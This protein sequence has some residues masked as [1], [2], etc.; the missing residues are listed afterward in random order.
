[1]FNRFLTSIGAASI[2]LLASCSTQQL[3]RQNEQND[4]VYYSKARAVEAEEQVK[5]EAK[6]ADYVT[7]QELYG[8]RNS[9]YDNSSDYEEGFYDG[10]YS[11]RLYRFNNYTPWRSYYDSYYDYRF[12]PFYG[13]NYYSNNYYNSFYNGAS[14]GIYIGV[15]RPYGYNYYN[16]WNFYGSQYY[17][18]YWGP[19]SY[20]NVYNPYYGG[21]YSY[22]GGNYGYNGRPVVTNPNY[23]TRPNRETENIRSGV[24][25]PD[26]RISTNPSRPQRTSTS[27]KEQGTFTERTSDNSQPVRVSRPSRSE[28]GRSGNVTQEKNNNRPA[29]TEVSRPSRPSRESNPPQRTENR[30]AERQSSQP[31]TAPAKSSENDNSRPRRSGGR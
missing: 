20:Y 25:N 5:K 16:P 19:Y 2:F 31:S 30:P 4:D 1:M 8:D 10:S 9:S 22:G 7:D 18:S 13:N 15:G 23:R 24:Y 26:G 21:G 27:P 6:S 12:D 11:A 28:D 29:Q 3:A 14:F 17:G